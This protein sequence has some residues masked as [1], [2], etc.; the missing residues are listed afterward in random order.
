M[1]FLELTTS[2]LIAL[3]LAMDAFAVSIGVSTSGQVPQLRSKLRLAGH[4]GIFQGGMTI[5]GWLAGETIVQWIERWDHWLAFGLL[6]YVGANMIRSSLSKADEEVQVDPSKGWSLVILSVAT[7]LDALAVG[8]S[9][10]LV[11][12]PVVIPSILIALVAFGLSCVGLFAGCKL[13]EKFGK[14]ME[15][16]GGLVLIGIGVRILITH[17]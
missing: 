9:F 13:G 12:T 3:G 6:L 4:F 10:A 8:L 2:F 5:L 1:S 11:K 15:I 7:S 17:L 16:V 14:R